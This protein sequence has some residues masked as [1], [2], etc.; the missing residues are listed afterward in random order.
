MTCTGKSENVGGLK[1][2]GS[3]DRRA[4]R[5][6]EV[7]R[8]LGSRMGIVGMEVGGAATGEFALAPRPRCLLLDCKPFYE[9]NKYLE[10]CDTR[11]DLIR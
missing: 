1:V 5:P 4:E 6:V 9:N 3:E 7:N 2:K 11:I 10:I 8:E